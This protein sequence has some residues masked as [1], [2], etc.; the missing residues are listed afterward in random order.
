MALL[1]IIIEARNGTPSI[2]YGVLT[3]NIPGIGT[4]D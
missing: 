1:E 3:V 4:M 2:V